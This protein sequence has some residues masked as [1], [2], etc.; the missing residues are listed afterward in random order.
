MHTIIF[1][2]FYVTYKSFR[3]SHFRQPLSNFFFFFFVDYPWNT[4][5]TSKPQCNIRIFAPKIPF[6]SSLWM[7]KKTSVY[8]CVREGEV[9]YYIVTFKGKKVNRPIF[10]F[11][12][13]KAFNPKF[14]SIKNLT[15]LSKNSPSS[16]TSTP[17][18]NLKPLKP[19]PLYG[20]LDEGQSSTCRKGEHTIFFQNL[21]QLCSFTAD[22]HYLEN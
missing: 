15:P 8:V 18:Y 7:T 1:C 9:D 20:F 10:I 5:S 3:S 6:I 21:N 14:S 16:F 2:F 13:Q 22:Y 17:L 19:L 11:F 4:A 12:F